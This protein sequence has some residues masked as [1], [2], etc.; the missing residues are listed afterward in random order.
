MIVDIV[1]LSSTSSHFL[2]MN[3]TYTVTCHVCTNRQCLWNLNYCQFAV[4]TW[5]QWETLLET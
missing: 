2:V 4:S 1:A 5:I 3:I